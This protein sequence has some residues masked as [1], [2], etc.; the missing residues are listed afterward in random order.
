M[1]PSKLT[2]LITVPTEENLKKINFGELYVQI[3]LKA[4]MKVKLL[5]FK[6]FEDLIRNI[7][8]N[9]QKFLKKEKKKTEIEAEDHMEDLSVVNTRSRAA[10]SNSDQ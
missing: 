5:F 1:E 10:E 3:E 2:T 9:N 7:L 4:V 6:W 8:K